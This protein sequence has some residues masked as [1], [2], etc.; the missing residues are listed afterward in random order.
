MSAPYYT[1][2]GVPLKFI[3]SDADGDVSPT[4]CEVTILGPGNTIS[5][6]TATIDDNEVSCNVPGSVTCAEGLYKV[7]FVLTLPSEL[8]RTHKIEFNVI[9]NPE[10]NK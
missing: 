9:I 2:D 8:E 3:V 1:G 7:Y 10:V 5:E 4:A 6:G